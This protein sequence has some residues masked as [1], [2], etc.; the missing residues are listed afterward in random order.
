[1]STKQGSP[2]IDALPYTGHASLARFLSVM[3]IAPSPKGREARGLPHVRPYAERTISILSMMSLAASRTTCMHARISSS[4]LPTA[5]D[6][7]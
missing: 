2:S 5:Q 4:D 6:A 1:M 3:L 7:T